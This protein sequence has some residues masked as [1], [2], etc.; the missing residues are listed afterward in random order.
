M[1]GTA[2]DSIEEKRRQRRWRRWLFNILLLPPALLYILIENLYWAAA[3]A[4]LHASRLDAINALQRGMKRLPPAAIL[5][6]F[7]VPEA[8][9]HLGGWW[10]TYLLVKR[11]WWSAVWAGVLI[12]GFATLL[13]VWIYQTCQP[14]LMSVNWFA[15]LHGK[16][17]TVRNWM[18]ERT[19]PAR[20]LCRR[21]VAGSRSGI[22][23]RFLAL[24]SRI[25]NRLGLA[26]K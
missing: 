17:Q 22:S 6:L 19:E 3:R 24:R 8:I 18:A 5:P 9:S 26:R 15:R 12:K 2:A 13:V 10:A 4:A 23:R 25:A 16:F 1:T 14:A 21:L 7:L 11:K 20:R